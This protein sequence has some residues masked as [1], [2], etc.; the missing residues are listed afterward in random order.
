MTNIPKEPDIGLIRSLLHYDPET[1][2]LT[3]KVQRGSRAKVGAIAGCVRGTDG[4]LCVNIKECGMM[5]AHRLAW[6]IVTGVWPRRLI[7]HRNCVRA[8]NRWENLREADDSANAYN[9]SIKRNN[10]SG[11]K[12]VN[13]DKTKNK[14]SAKI[15]IKKRRYTIGLYSTLEDAALAYESAAKRLHGEFANT[16]T[17]FLECV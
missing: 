15:Q 2:H 17:H 10:T 11:I 9:Q 3:W 8:D 1:G 16:S 12:G 7:D 13:W 6:A 14:F 5:Q 4:Y